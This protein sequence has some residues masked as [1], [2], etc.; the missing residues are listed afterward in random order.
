MKLVSNFM[1]MLIVRISDIGKPKI[2][3]G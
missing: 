1:G 2:Y 3:I